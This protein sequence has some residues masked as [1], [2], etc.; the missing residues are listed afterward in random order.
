[1]RINFAH[2]AINGGNRQKGSHGGQNPKDGRRRHFE[3]AFNGALYGVPLSS[4]GRVNALAHDHRIIHNDAER[5]D[6]TKGGHLVD[7]QPNKRVGHKKQGAKE[8]KGQTS[9]DPKCHAQVKK[10]RQHNK[11]HRNTG[12]RVGGKQ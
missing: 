10:Q 8:D 2:V 9:C 1:M 12:E 3:R 6:E 11:H 7:G 4:A 5:H